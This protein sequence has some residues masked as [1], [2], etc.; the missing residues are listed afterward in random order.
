MTVGLW[1]SFTENF[2]LGLAGVADAGEHL[3]G[4]QSH[5]AA[6]VYAKQTAADQGLNADAQAQLADAAARTEAQPGFLSKAWHNTLNDLSGGALTLLSVL[7]YA[8]YIAVAIA[9]AVVLFLYLPRR[10]TA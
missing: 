3:V 8:L 4:I 2:E 9:V 7:K 6:D 10:R 5:H 1:D